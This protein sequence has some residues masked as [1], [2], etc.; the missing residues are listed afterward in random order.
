MNGYLLEHMHE[1]NSE[2]GRKEMRLA[3]FK[4]TLASTNIFT[5]WQ[6]YWTAFKRYFTHYKR[7]N[8]STSEAEG[9]HMSKIRK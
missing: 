9:P 7:F 6:A 1:I 8:K 3:Q 4:S 5:F 2:A